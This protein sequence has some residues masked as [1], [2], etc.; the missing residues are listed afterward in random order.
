M[1]L[2]HLLWA[3]GSEPTVVTNGQPPPRGISRGL[4][5][6]MSFSLSCPCPGAAQERRPRRGSRH[7]MG[8]GDDFS[9]TSRGFARWDV[10]VYY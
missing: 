5:V 4:G 10:L 1:A 2:L 9:S 7:S 8:R 3:C 6:F